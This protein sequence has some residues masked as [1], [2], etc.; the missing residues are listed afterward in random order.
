MVT[1]DVT[2]KMDSPCLRN[3]NITALEAAAAFTMTLLKVEKDV[4]VAVYKQKEVSII[5]LD[6]SMWLFSG[7]ISRSVHNT[8]FSEAQFYEHVQK[9]KENKSEYLVPVAPVEWAM[10]QKKHIDIFIN[11]IHHN[12][13]Y[14]SIPKDVKD[15]RGKPAETL[16][17][18]RKKFNLQNAK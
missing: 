17:K 8:C 3:K 9:L 18:Y 7:G 16:Q 1:I 6:K 11:F 2:N 12:E 10:S 5:H 13:Y 15:R 14:T 4:T